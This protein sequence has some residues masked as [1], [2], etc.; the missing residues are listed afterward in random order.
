MPCAFADH[1]ARRD[2]TAGRR[3]CVRHATQARTDGAASGPNDAHASI[4]CERDVFLKCAIYAQN[5]RRFRRIQA[6]MRTI[7]ERWC[8]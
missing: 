7:L 6:E 3:G 5:A 2:Y 4:D 8:V 1:S